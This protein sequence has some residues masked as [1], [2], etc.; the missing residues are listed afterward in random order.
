MHRV[1]SRRTD[2]GFTI[3]ESVIALGLLFTVVLGLLGALTAGARG[4]L[5][6]RNR[7]TATAIANE[8]VEQARARSYAE[9]G[10]ALA[11][12]AT[13][14]ADGALVHTGGDYVYGGEKLAGS[15]VP[16]TNPPFTPHRW[17]RSV[18]N[19]AFT[20][21]VYVT[22]VPA[23][24]S[25]YKR[26]TVNVSWGDGSS[27]AAK[28]I[29]L[30]TL[31][32][33]AEQPPDPLLKGIADADAGTIAVGGALIGPD[34]DDAHRW[35][36]FTHGEI[37]SSFVKRVKGFAIGSRSSLRMRTGTPSTSGTSCTSSGVEA[38]CGD[39]KQ[40]TIADNDA[41][42]T[43]PDA[44]TV[45]PSSAVATTIDSSTLSMSTGSGTASSQSTARA[46]ATCR[47]VVIGDGDDL[48]YHTSAVG[49]PG[50]FGTTF[51]SG[52]VAGSIVRA[53]SGCATSD[54]CSSSTVDVDGTGTALSVTTTAR[55]SVPAVDVLDLTGAPSGFHGMVRVSSTDVTATAAAGAAAMAPTISATPM[56]IQLWD[57]DTDGET[58]PAPGYRSFTFTPGAA[59]SGSSHADL[60]I[61][62]AA[63]SMDADFRAL[64]GATSSVAGAVSGSLDH[65]EARLADWLRVTVHVV[66]IQGGGATIDMT[67]ELD[68][69]R[70]SA[71][72]D[73]RAAA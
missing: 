32:Y 29:R 63:V 5:L 42:T 64:R 15:M 18:D 1:V 9:V 33:D 30:S 23:A 44:D 38:R 3:V 20:A 69:G 25:P 26:V 51:S 70:V 2:G 61:G 68:Y 47:A 13:L 65:A 4:V 35:F 7:T 36:G 54:R 55:T 39:L 12:D 22:L 28:S 60:T 72:A 59:A 21:T 11:S 52:S 31:M 6:G 48:P 50:G 17:T 27:G 53:A 16:G 40:E 34:V 43:P 41:G 67:V 19:V 37:D 56:T 58:W 71:I 46:C 10:H 57:S 49:G 73:Y 14:A 45:G 62:S 8:V 66:I 24:T